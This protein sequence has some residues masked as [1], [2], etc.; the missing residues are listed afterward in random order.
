MVPLS[1]FFLVLAWAGV[2]QLEWMVA[3]T[4]IRWR[5]RKHAELTQ[6]AGLE[7]KW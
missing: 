2:A 5:V 3:E 6:I 4:G 1:G 7:R